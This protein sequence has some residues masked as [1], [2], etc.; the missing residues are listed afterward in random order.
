MHYCCFITHQ[1]VATYILNTNFNIKFC[2][3][4]CQV[5]AIF[6]S[7]PPE[8][9]TL[10]YTDQ[11]LCFNSSFHPAYPVEYLVNITDVRDSLVFRY[12][13]NTSRCLENFF[14]C[15]E[16]PYTVSVTARNS[17]GGT[18][19]SRQFN[20]GT[21]NLAQTLSTM[22]IMVTLQDTQCFKF[23]TQNLSLFFLALSKHKLQMKQLITLQDTQCF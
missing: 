19:I 9:L 4:V 14:L 11:R 22:L 6:Y 15:R 1:I 3:S 16:G 7:G 8:S 5:I 17:F 21:G 20:I 18:S 10:S 2:L 12:I 13:Y 23:D